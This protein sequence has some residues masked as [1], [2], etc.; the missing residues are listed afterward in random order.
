[1]ES[2]WKI[3]DSVLG[4]INFNF[5]GYTA[6]YN[7]EDTREE[8]IIDTLHRYFQ[9]RGKEKDS[10][11]IYDSTNDIKVSSN[12][13]QAFII[14]N[15]SI[16]EE[17]DISSKSYTNKILSRR[18]KDNREADGYL[19]TI[20]TLVE[21]LLVQVRGNLPLEAKQFTY[22]LLTKL[23]EYKYEANKEYENLITQIE[24]LLPLIMEEIIQ[25]SKGKALIIYKYPE[26]YLSPKEQIRLKK[27]FDNFTNIPIIVLTESQY[28]LSN[29]LLGNNY[30]RNYNQMIS[31]S[32]IEELV[33]NA[34]LNFSEEN[35]VNSL[36][37]VIYSYVDKLEVSPTI[38]NYNLTAVVL[39]DSIDIYTCFM[40]M[41]RCN[42]DFE[43]DLDERRCEKAILSYIY[44]HY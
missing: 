8:H 33:W 3:T 29:R 30:Y 9:P 26:A 19:M 41:R 17:I 7:V 27:L 37:K 25:Q 39:F 16:H 12:H 14:E 40:F 22:S 34:P 1:M 6:I 5:G 28:F 24:Y 36:Q 2:V 18:L 31:Y 35:L 10:I 11:K 32:L 44:D 23:I 42:Y 13:Y 21:D 4:N 38:S 15:K 43:V 20:N